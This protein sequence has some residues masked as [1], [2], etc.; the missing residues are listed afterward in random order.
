VKESRI[1]YAIGEA[2]EGQEELV[3]QTF[4]IVKSQ[5]EYRN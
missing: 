5:P 2:L 4:E 3:E 1:R